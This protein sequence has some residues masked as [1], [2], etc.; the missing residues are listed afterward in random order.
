M[1]YLINTSSAALKLIARALHAEI[2]GLEATP[3]EA[4]KKRLGGHVG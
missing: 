2:D 1:T 4:N 3:R